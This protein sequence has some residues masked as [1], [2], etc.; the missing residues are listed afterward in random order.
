MSEHKTILCIFCRRIIRS[1]RCYQVGTQKVDFSICDSCMESQNIR[2]KIHK[3]SDGWK[4]SVKSSNEV[5]WTSVAYSSADEAA[6]AMEWTVDIMDANMMR[7][8]LHK[9]YNSAPKWV[10][11]VRSMTD[12]QVVA[13][14]FRM[15]SKKEMKS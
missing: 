6:R 15:N 10:E 1:C 9:Q 13:V 2:F 14:Y 11:K 3:D 7:L 8:W 12:A 4:W 5:V